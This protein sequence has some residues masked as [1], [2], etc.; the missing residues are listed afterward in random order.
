MSDQCEP[1]MRVRTAHR[2]RC[3]AERRLTGVRARSESLLLFPLRSRQSV[4]K[5]RSTKSESD[6]S[7]DAA[8]PVGPVNGG[9][10][11]INCNDDQRFSA[12]GGARAPGAV[13][14]GGGGDTGV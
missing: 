5:V 9:T 2:D 7:H 12:G 14:G 1:D 6:V 10:V 11:T 13:M 4:S 8:Q 3:H